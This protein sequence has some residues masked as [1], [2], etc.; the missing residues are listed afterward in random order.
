LFL[1]QGDELGPGVKRVSTGSRI[2][3]VSGYLLIDAPKN[4]SGTENIAYFPSLQ[5]KTPSFIYY[6]QADTNATYNRDSFYFELEPFSLNGMDSL[7]STEVQLDGKLFSGGQLPFRTMVASVLRP[8]RK[9]EAR[10]PTAEKE[11]MRE[12]LC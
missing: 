6:D 3:H 8:K 12:R 10:M 2:E 1:P 5:S 9:K 7:I 4:K 11:S